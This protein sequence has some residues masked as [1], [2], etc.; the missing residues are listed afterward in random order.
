MERHGIS[1]K[2]VNNKQG[3]LY[4]ASQIDSG[5]V[6]QPLREPADED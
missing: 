3:R 6:S 4:A 2:I 1:L 5:G